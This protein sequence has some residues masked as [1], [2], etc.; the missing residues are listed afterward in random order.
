MHRP[1]LVGR[2]CPLP[3]TSNTEAGIGCLI[4]SRESVTQSALNA[5]NRR[6]LRRRKMLMGHLDTPHD[7]LDVHPCR[8]IDQHNPR[9]M[10]GR[11]THR[12]H[13][14]QPAV[15]HQSQNQRTQPI[16]VRAERVRWPG[17]NSAANPEAKTA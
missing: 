3:I 4:G 10:P 15:R 12:S 13:G 11:I 7:I 14:L 17:T 9:P 16:N 1:A 5:A 6:A 8:C 2:C